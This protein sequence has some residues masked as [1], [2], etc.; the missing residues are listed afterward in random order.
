MSN[1]TGTRVALLEA[2]MSHEIADMIRRYGGEPCCAPAVRETPL[3]SD[4]QVATFIDHLTNSEL[5]TAVFL[6]GVGVNALM[7]V[8]EKLGREEELLTALRK[9][10][11][12]CRG[13]KPGA[14]LKRLPVPIA[15]SAA[16]PYTTKELLE[17]MQPLTLQ[18]VGVVHY[19]ERNAQL[20]QELQARGARVEELMLYEWQLPEDTTPMH[21]LVT[22][23]MEKRIGA[24]VFTSQVQVRHLFL[25]A[26]VPVGDLVHAL[27]T[28]TVV[29]S[30]GPTCTA[31]LR[32]W[33]VTPHVEPVH[34]KIGHLLKALNEH[35]GSKR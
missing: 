22:N 4:K 10:T 29:A 31:A 11:V 15:A 12:A 33:G 13:P 26:G 34:P 30:I 20:V 27:N 1:L 8:A 3:D 9:I 17:A 21:E 16:E 18:D 35:M 7:R 2:R 5:Q 6:T 23:I 25:I 32:E 24:V 14:V 19:G 28:Q